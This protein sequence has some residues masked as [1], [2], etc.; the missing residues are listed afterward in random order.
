MKEFYPTLYLLEI[1]L[2]E[3][4]VEKNATRYDLQNTRICRENRNRLMASAL[5]ESRI[6][7]HG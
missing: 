4:G 1:G 7:K 5:E 3:N 2:A 6:E